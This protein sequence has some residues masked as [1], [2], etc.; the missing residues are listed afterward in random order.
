M[1]KLFPYIFNYALV[2]LLGHLISKIGL[3]S[4]YRL[5]IYILPAFNLLAISYTIKYPM[6]RKKDVIKSE[7]FKT[8]LIAT[9]I[10]DTL[11]VIFTEPYFA[12]WLVLIISNAIELYLMKPKTE[13]INEETQKNIAEYYKKHKSGQLK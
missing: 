2:M 9:T 1:K 12:V 6:E 5:P 11:I 3:T 10:I 8:L 4:I 13:K 7:V